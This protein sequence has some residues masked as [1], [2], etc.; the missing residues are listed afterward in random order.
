MPLPNQPPG[1]GQPP[2]RPSGQP[3][4]GAQPQQR[5][6]GQPAAGPQRPTP[7]T[8]IPPR[9]AGQPGTGTPGQQRLPGQPGQ[10]APR[11]QLEQ[12]DVQ[13]LSKEKIRDLFRSGNLPT[14]EQIVDE[15]IWRATKI[16]ANDIHFESLEGQLRIRIGHE[17]VLKRIVSL[18]PDLTENI[19]SIL[20][21][22]TSLNQFEKRKPQ[23]GR[24]S[25]S[26]HG[27]QYDFR[28]STIPV[29]NGERALLRILKKTTQVQQLE[30]LG[31][32]DVILERIRTLLRQP[33][34]LLLVTGPSGSGKTTTV[35]AATNAVETPEKCII[36]V[37]DPVE[38]RLPFA[39]QVQLPADKSFNFVDALRAILR[40]N[41]NAILI[42][43]IRDAETGTVA[44][45]AAVTGNLVL[46]TML[47]DNSIGSIH[48]LLNIG[49]KPYWLSATL[50]GVIYQQLMRKVCTSCKE[51]Y[52]PSDVEVELI[53][54]FLPKSDLNFSFGRGCQDCGNSG[55]LGRT[56]ICEIISATDRLR[57]LILKQST[58]LEMH[59][60]ALK[61]GFEDIRFDA[62]RKVAAGI[63]TISEFIRV[64]G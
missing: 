44:A 31:F 35:Y 6:S 50:V 40:Q 9:P 28:I 5:P 33:K 61:N 51:E 2:Q 4:G 60:E 20:K 30:E 49:L 13:T 47:A 34:G 8:P 10:S 26:Y 42:G 3:A 41:P 52:K 22:K 12:L 16:G 58:I 17:G 45:E 55:Y 18:P 59:D 64:L 23:E 36:T 29:L 54:P 46:S 62:A 63:S 43:E 38:Y 37:E 19:L 57:D 15:L 14:A 25:A 53:S 39:S 24:Y 7:G 48:R 27:D 1:P 56:A 32:T 11:V 21:T